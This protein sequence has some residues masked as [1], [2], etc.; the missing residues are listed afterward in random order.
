MQ[1]RSRFWRSVFLPSCLA[2][3]WHTVLAC[4]ALV[5]E[6]RKKAALLLCYNL[7]S[8]WLTHAYTLITV[9]R[10]LASFL[11]TTQRLFWSSASWPKEPRWRMSIKCTK[12]LCVI[13]AVKWKNH[14]KNYLCMNRAFV[15]STNT[16]LAFCLSHCSSLKLGF[17]DVDGPVK[18]K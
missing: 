4:V 8:R 5:T 11:L 17:E 10:P 1:C 16:S 12:F 14:S 6:K 2:R 3:E 7:F 15:H 9:K 13:N 18:W